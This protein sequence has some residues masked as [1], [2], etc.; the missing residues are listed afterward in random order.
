MK[1]T[2]RL[3]TS[4]WTVE[5]EIVEQGKVRVLNYS[6]T[7]AEG[8][9]RENELPQCELRETDERI[10]THL[11][12]KPFKQGEWVTQENAT[13]VYEVINPQFIFSYSEQ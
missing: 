1:A 5:Y 13:E 10:V 2:K 12:I 6:R 7:D 4:I 3:I 11:Y 8:Y 9:Q